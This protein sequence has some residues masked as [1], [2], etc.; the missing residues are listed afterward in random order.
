MFGGYY[1]DSYHP[2]TT[3]LRQN[4]KY[5]QITGK[6]PLKPRHRPI[7]AILPTLSQDT[8]NST[9]RHATDSQNDFEDQK[10]RKRSIPTCNHRQSASKKPRIGCSGNLE[11]ER[12]PQGHSQLASQIVSGILEGVDSI[13]SKRIPSSWS[14]LTRFRPKRSLA[15]LAGAWEQCVRDEEA[16]AERSKRPTKAC[17]EAGPY[18]KRMVSL[19][20]CFLE[21]AQAHTHKRSRISDRVRAH[22][23]N[24]DERQQR[25]RV[26]E[27]VVWI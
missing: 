7:P 6:K 15:D 10:S 27:L 16:Y 3:I 2:Q 8:S 26:G 14:I 13:K 20:R 19:I 25:R 21:I 1:I 5:L 12:E 24:K 18:N 4:C 23:G 22:A 9:L 11:D 17:V